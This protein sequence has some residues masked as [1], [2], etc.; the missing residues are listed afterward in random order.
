MQHVA[1]TVVF[2]GLFVAAMVSFLMAG[3]RQYRRTCRLRRR[4]EELGLRFSHSDPFDVPNRYANFALMAAGHSPFAYNM[5]YGR[6]DG[7]SV[8]G[9]DF[10]HEL[11]HGT[12]RMTVHYS[13][14]VAQTE[15]EMPYVLMW[16]EE[17][18]GEVPLVVLHREGTIGR[19]RYAGSAEMAAELA[20]ACDPSSSGAVSL[21]TFGSDLML[22][23]PVRDRQPD[24]T[25]GLGDLVRLLELLRARGPADHC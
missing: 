20:E 4:A 14:V 15:I 2:T 19:W 24:Y 10:R 5:A 22:W 16:H 8:R 23:A 17:H 11:G 13:V 1:L 18:L 3:A 21:Q 12:Q 25:G 6:L 7:W 9:F